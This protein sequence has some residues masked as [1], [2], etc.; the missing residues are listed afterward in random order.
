[1]FMSISCVE[2]KFI[3]KPGSQKPKSD[4]S[5]F[6]S[7]D[8]HPYSENVLI[9]VSKWKEYFKE[10]YDTPSQ[11]QISEKC[12]TF[13]MDSKKTEPFFDFWPGIIRFPNAY[14]NTDIVNWDD[15]LA[16]YMPEGNNYYEIG[17]FIPNKKEYIPL[18]TNNQTA[19]AIIVKVFTKQNLVFFYKSKRKEEFQDLWVMNLDGTNQI[20]ITNGTYVMV[21]DCILLDNER[22]FIDCWHEKDKTSFNYSMI[23]Y[24]KQNKKVIIN[25]DKTD[26]IHYRYLGVYHNHLVMNVYCID[27]LKEEIWL[28]DFDGNKE[29]TIYAFDNIFSDS[30]SWQEFL[31]DEKRECIFFV[32]EST[33]KKDMI[34]TLNLRTSEMKDIFCQDFTSFDPV[35]YLNQE[36]NT[37]YFTH[38]IVDLKD[39]KPIFEKVLHQIDLSTLLDNPLPLPDYAENCFSDDYHY[40]FSFYNDSTS[41]NNCI[42]D[43]RTK[44]KTSLN[45]RFHLDYTYPVYLPS[46]KQFCFLLE[47]ENPKSIFFIDLDGNVTSYDIRK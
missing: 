28:Y 29:Q 4:F 17:R 30:Y 42:I 12:Y 35:L 40:V 14:K 2:T 21:S 20:N 11:T 24:P 8:A 39:D 36:N 13:N 26:R 44:K 19:N 10:G 41:K 6:T 31:F 33:D 37:L 22:I 1:M 46:S 45:K 15:F 47:S 34:S 18:I 43:T 9:T 27:T 16:D 38:S 23:Y 5:Y 32:F 7:V 25:K 3:A